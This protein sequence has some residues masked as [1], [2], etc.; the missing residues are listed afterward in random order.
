M[1]DW[2]DYTFMQRALVATSVLSFSVAPVGA[3]LVL[4][5]LSLA[6]EAMAHAIVPGIVIAFV[7]AGL[8]VASMIVGGL[9]AGITVAVLTTLLSRLT[10]IREDASL[11]SLYLIALALGIFILSASGSAVPLK[12]FLFGSILGIDDETLVLI[13]ATATIT[14]IS[15]A[16]ILRP[17]IVS[18]IDP[19]FYESQAQRPG[20]VGQWFMFLVV[21]NLLGA[22]KA[23][24]TLMAVGLM[25]LPATAARYWVS[26]ITSYLVL[27]FVFALTSSWA[28]LV[29][30]YYAPEVPSGPAIVLVAGSLFVISLLLGPQGLRLT[31]KRS[32]RNRDDRARNAGG[33]RTVPR[34]SPPSNR[35]GRLVMKRFALRLATCAF[36]VAALIAPA[37]AD[38]IKVV[39][40]FSILG[41]MVEQVTGDL[42]TVTTI[43]GPNAD[44]HVYAPNVRDARAVTDADV[45]F[46]NGLGFETWSKTLIETSGT[47]A[48]V[49]VA[50]DGV[51]PLKVDGE[52]D[53][54][55]WNALTNGVKYVRNIAT[56]MSQIDA[57][58]AAAY[59]ANADV[60]VAKLTALHDRTVTELAALPKDRRTVVTAHDA[61]GYL[62]NAYGLNFL[63]PVG[64][65]TEAEPSAQQLAKLIDQLKPS[66]SPDCLLK[67]S[68]VPR[69]LSRLRVRPD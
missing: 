46:V 24:G 31:T 23:L 32:R 3:F 56:A 64:I 51:T 47:K 30:S 45:I 42:A 49:F 40:S 55:A 66:R 4:R 39:A 50:T 38:K 27:T 5:R 7:I 34:I 12:S 43:V 57:D 21:L 52:I 18:T 63:A 15:F 20:L 2:L 9:I 48:R 11:A 14:L 62:A 6:G 13:G 69:W 26:M 29:I 41:D 17:L 10:I 53:P 59:K 36:A 65:D 35:K 60:Y 8:S 16:I 44:A 1:F 54:H 68:P 28:G 25:I 58:N 67:T 37:Q 22:F 19:V 61:F 33:C